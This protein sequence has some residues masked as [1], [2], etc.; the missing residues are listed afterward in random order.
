MADELARSEDFQKWTSPQDMHELEKVAEWTI[1]IGYY[2][3]EYLL[4]A[5]TAEQGHIYT[6]L[7]EALGGDA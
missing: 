4:E 3:A 1:A 5:T 7:M 2:L 6:L